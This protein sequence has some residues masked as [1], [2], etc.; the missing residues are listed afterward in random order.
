MN[1]KRKMKTGGRRRARRRIGREAV[2]LTNVIAVV[3]VAPSAPGI[4]LTI[5]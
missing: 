2:Q 5:A 4:R 3:T 1:C